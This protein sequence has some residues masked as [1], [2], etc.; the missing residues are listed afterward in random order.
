M[1]FLLRDHQGKFLIAKAES[2]HVPIPMDAMTAKQPFYGSAGRIIFDYLLLASA[3][4]NP[5]SYY[6]SLGLIIQDCID[7]AGAGNTRKF[8]LISC[9]DQRT[10]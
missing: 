3:I 1:G 6:S 9:D 4:N 8:R 2:A 10:M 5:G 7:L